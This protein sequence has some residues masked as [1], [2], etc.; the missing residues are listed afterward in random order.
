MPNNF[1]IPYNTK[2]GGNGGVN[3]YEQ[4]HTAQGWAKPDPVRRTTECIVHAGYVIPQWTWLMMREDGTVV[5]HSGAPFV[6]EWLFSGSITTGKTVTFTNNVNGSVYTFTAPKD[7]TAAAL[8]VEITKD[9]SFIAI[10]NQNNVAFNTNNNILQYKQIDLTEAFSI[11]SLNVTITT[12][13]SSLSISNQKNSQRSTSSNDVPK[14]VG[15]MA[16]D[17]C[18]YNAS[19]NATNTPAQMFVAGSRYNTSVWWANGI[20]TLTDAWGIARNVTAYDTGVTNMIAAN[21]FLQNTDF[22]I[23]QTI[24]A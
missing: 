10:L 8:M 9:A 20:E 21:A 2:T 18:A 19:G 24:E 3:F 1:G 23:R 12:N 16:F 5:P 15:L 6:S 17:V 22:E 4:R 13:A 14:V 7:L 11:D